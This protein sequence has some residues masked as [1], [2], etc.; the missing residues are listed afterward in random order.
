MRAKANAKR[1]EAERVKREERE[2]AARAQVRQA[3]NQ[4]TEKF[5][6][7]FIESLLPPFTYRFV[8]LSTALFSGDGRF[9]LHSWIMS[10]FQFLFL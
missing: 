8:C 9:N 7:S 5:R 1:V 10:S 6:V 4:L 3:V 2:A